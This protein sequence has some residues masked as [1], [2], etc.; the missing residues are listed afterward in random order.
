M[1]FRMLRR[2]SVFNL[3]QLERCRAL[4]GLVLAGLVS[5][6]LVACINKGDTNIGS[7]ENSKS[8]ETKAEPDA[9][10]ALSDDE[11][12]SSASDLDDEASNDESLPQ[13]D[14]DVSDAPETAQSNSDKPAIAPDAA[15]S[16]DTSKPETVS[17]N[18]G[19]SA[20]EADSDA[21]EQATDETTVEPDAPC[22]GQD[23]PVSVS[24]GYDSTCGITANGTVKCWGSNTY[25]QLGSGVD[26]YSKLA[27][28]VPGLCARQIELGDWHACAIDLEGKVVCWGYNEQGQLGNGSKANSSRPRAV[29]IENVLQ[30]AA[31]YSHTCALIEGGTV[32]C[33]GSN[34][35]GELGNAGDTT[36]L[37]DEPQDVL[38]L[39]DAKVVQI[40]A[41]YGFTCALLD[42]GTVRCWGSNGNGQLGNGASQADSL[43]PVD[44]LE[45]EDATQITLGYYQVC[46]HID[47]DGISCWGGDEWTTARKGPYDVPGEVAGFFAAS[48]AAGGS[49]TCSLNTD[50]GIECWGQNDHGQLGYPTIQMQSR[51]APEPIGEVS[52]GATSL[53]LGYSHGCMVLANDV[54]KCWGRGDS[55]Q[56]GNGAAG[57][58]DTPVKVQLF[59]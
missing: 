54:V 26:G 22:A 50:S 58:S 49:M 3:V 8:T 20:S 47:G 27:V 29:E 11:T 52:E 4:L 18:D 55:G 2:Q 39:D 12:Q 56:L 17:E 25:G 6:N 10:S 45:L 24:A 35:F 48:V 19:T 33:W 37:F 51:T 15:T 36:E 5:V 34:L 14:E 9:G 1:E 40:D 31:G 16:H 41:G 28:T 43:L 7:K 13:R 23:I 42:T 44:V 32:K 21:G 30:I 59:P 57:D 46:A 53:S 38:G